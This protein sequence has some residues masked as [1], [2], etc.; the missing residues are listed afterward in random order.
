LDGGER[1]RRIWALSDAEAIRAL[2]VLLDERGLRTAAK[3]LSPTV[4]QCDA[5]DAG[6]LRQFAVLG[7]SAASEADLARSILEY[8]AVADSGV[9]AEAVDYAR[10]PSERVDLETISVMAAVVTLLQTEVVVK[11]NVRGQW[12]LIVHKH[13]TRDSALG[14]VL[15]ALYSRI[16]GGQGPG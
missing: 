6:E 8:T 7:A 9:V 3:E 2:V 11:R 4:A 13:A 1:A 16:G 10:S 5:L 14:R 12:S 15:S